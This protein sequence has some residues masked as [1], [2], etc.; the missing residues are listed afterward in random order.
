M[1]QSSVRAKRKDEWNQKVRQEAADRKAAIQQEKLDKKTA[2]IAAKQAKIDEKRFAAEERQDEL[3]R[4]WQAKE[5]AKSAKSTNRADTSIGR[6]LH[7]KLQIEYRSWHEKRSE[8]KSRRCAEFV[9]QAREAEGMFRSIRVRR[10]SAAERACMAEKKTFLRPSIDTVSSVSSLFQAIRFRR[11]PSKPGKKQQSP[12]LQE[13]KKAAPPPPAKQRTYKKGAPPRRYASPTT[14]DFT[15]SLSPLQ[16]AYDDSPEHLTMMEYL[17]SLGFSRDR[18]SRRN[19]SYEED[20][21]PE[22]V[23]GH[24][25]GSSQKQ[26]HPQYAT[27]HITAGKKNP[28]PPPRNPAVRVRRQRRY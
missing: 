12:P 20:D 24:L 4:R 6:A 7:K 1:R 10:R 9:D 11:R 13:S 23:L 18:R 14:S 2:K 16:G 8:Q 26:K 21:A 5:D 3:D 19:L 17:S 15:P 25:F 27:V 28:P 22:T